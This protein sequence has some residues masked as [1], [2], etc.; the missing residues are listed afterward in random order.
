MLFLSNDWI[1]WVAEEYSIVISAV[2]V[3]LGLIAK[4]IAIVHPG[5]ERDDIIGLLHVLGGRK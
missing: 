1:M 5:V 2:P 3:I 4:I